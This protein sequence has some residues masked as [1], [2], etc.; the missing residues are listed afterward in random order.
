MGEVTGMHKQNSTWYVHCAKERRKDLEDFLLTCTGSERCIFKEDPLE[1]VGEAKEKHK[2]RVALGP[3]AQVDPRNLCGF[4]ISEAPQTEVLIIAE[5]TEEGFREQAKRAGALWVLR[6]EDTIEFVKLRYLA[7][8]HEEKISLQDRSEEFSVVS[9]A[10]RT[11]EKDPFQD[12]AAQRRFRQEMP[13]YGGNKEAFSVW[14][15]STRDGNAEEHAAKPVVSCEKSSQAVVPKEVPASACEQDDLDEPEGLEFDTNILRFDRC[16][17]FGQSHRSA[18]Q[19]PNTTGEG[20]ALVSSEAL[21]ISSPEVLNP[22]IVFASARGGVGKSTVASL[23]AL[24]T[25]RL[26]KRVALLDLDLNFGNIFGFFGRGRAADLT[27][28]SEG[29][30]VPALQK[31]GDRI[32]DYLDVYGSCE[33][34]EYAELIVPKIPEICATLSQMYEIVLIDTSSSWGDATASAAQMAHK[35]C[36]MSDERTGAIS[37]LARGAALLVR[38]GIPRTKVLRL[39]NRAD[40]K[41]RDQDFF[42]RKNPG[43]EQA[44]TLST[45]DGGVDVGEF[46]SAGDAPSLLDLDNVFASSCKSLCAHLLQ[47]VGS[48]P[49]NRL[50]REYLEGMQKPGGTL[51]QFAQRTLLKDVS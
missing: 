51:L 11:Y 18:L 28:L 24:A 22:L 30:N 17:D 32:N 2:V 8:E 26:E 27:P 19:I 10:P 5:V 15:A 3:G 31:C 50:A 38:L 42:A 44:T 13:T 21:S 48:L 49:E 40:P 25:A 20:E 12:E 45:F 33:K 35:I 39:I 7:D 34:P 4:L 36:L 6:A 29:V 46:L 43:L 41:K 23:V 37:S 16:S 1:L 14:E 47:E 9:S